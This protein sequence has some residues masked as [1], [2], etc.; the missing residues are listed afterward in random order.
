MVPDLSAQ[1]TRGGVGRPARARDSWRRRQPGVGHHDD[2]GED[3]PQPDRHVL[4]HDRED[5]VVAVGD[6]AAGSGLDQQDAL[7][8]QEVGQ[9]HHE[10]RDAELG[11]QQ[12]DAQA[13]HRPA[14]QRDDQRGHPGPAVVGHQDAEHA[15]GDT[16]GVAGRQVDLAQQE[17]EDQAHRE[18]RDRRPLQDQVREV[19][20]VGEGGPGQE[21]EDEHQHDQTGDRGE[22]PDVA[23]AEPDH[24]VVEGALEGLADD[25]RLVLADRG[26]LVLRRGAH[27]S[28]PLVVES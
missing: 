14:E 26:L 12:T 11:D 10:R 13:D 1:T 18:H 19:E 4:V 8:G 2:D 15:G 17:H 28:V 27:A 20:R 9:G 23:T 3:P 7:Q 24:V 22:G 21:G 25:G 6:G 16:S 5:R